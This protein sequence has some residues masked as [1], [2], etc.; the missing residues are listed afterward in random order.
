MHI[1][2]D[3]FGDEI[4]MYDSREE[5]TAAIGNYLSGNFAALTC[6]EVEFMRTC[7]ED[8]NLVRHEAEHAGRLSEEVDP[9]DVNGQVFIL[10]LGRTIEEGRDILME[11]IGPHPV[12]PL[13][14][15]EAAKSFITKR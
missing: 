14:L 7:E 15:L 2:T 4:V 9:L 5:E 3:R 11:R 8:P 1:E 10:D 6:A 13:T 12:T